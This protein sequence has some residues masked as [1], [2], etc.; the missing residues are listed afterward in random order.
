VGTWRCG[1]CE[2]E[3]RTGDRVKVTA[4]F[5]ATNGNV[6][7]LTGKLIDILPP[8][9]TGTISATGKPCRRTHQVKL[10]KPFVGRDYLTF[11]PEDLE[12]TK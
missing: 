12:K 8:K 1:D 11:C 7:E 10:D 5:R 3:V 2:K 6:S 4:A 9:F